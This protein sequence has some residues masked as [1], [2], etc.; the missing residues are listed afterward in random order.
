MH[1]TAPLIGAE[2]FYRKDLPFIVPDLPDIGKSAEGER[3]VYFI[4]CH[5]GQPL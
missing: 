3:A 4:S 1:D 5:Q 2:M